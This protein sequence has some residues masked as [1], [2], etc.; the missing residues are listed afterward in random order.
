MGMGV[1]VGSGVS[2][3]VTVG[4]GSGVLP[5]NRVSKKPG[6][7]VP[8]GSSAGVFP[9]S[10]SAEIAKMPISSAAMNKIRM[11]RNLSVILLR[12]LRRCLTI[13]QYLFI[14]Q[15]CFIIPFFVHR[16]NRRLATGY[17]LTVNSWACLLRLTWLP[18][19]HYTK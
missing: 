16:D 17:E 9:F 1:G 6:L 2:S 18:F 11:I 19:L 5:P 8:C 7:S 4:V 12:L 15:N 3:G 14:N 13:L 10:T